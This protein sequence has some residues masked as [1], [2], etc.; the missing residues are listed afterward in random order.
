[1]LLADRGIRIIATTTG[2]VLRQLDLD[3]TRPFQPT[4]KPKNTRP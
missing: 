4:E 1:M 3:P 2:E